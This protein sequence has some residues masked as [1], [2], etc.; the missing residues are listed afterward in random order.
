MLFAVAFTSLRRRQWSKDTASLRRSKL[1][2]KTEAHPTVSMQ[3]LQRELH[4]C[5]RRKGL[6]ILL[7]AAYDAVVIH[8]LNTTHIFTF[9][10]LGVW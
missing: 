5:V 7:M 9:N 8:T 3:R 10:G 6:Y 4:L 2:A 1:A